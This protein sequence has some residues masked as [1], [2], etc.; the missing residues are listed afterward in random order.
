MFRAAPILILALILAPSQVLAQG[1]GSTSRTSSSER[2]HAVRKA[3][4]GTVKSVD[5]ESGKIVVEDSKG[6]DH[7]FM[8]SKKTRYKAE[9]DTELAGIKIGLADFH[10]GSAVKITYVASSTGNNV[11]EIRLR[12]S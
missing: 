4:T 1:S 10:E 11:T 7:S 2:A 8:V 3:L 5:L 12:R 9:R 6:R